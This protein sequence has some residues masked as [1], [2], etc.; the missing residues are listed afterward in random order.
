MIM[1]D[2][3]LIFLKNRVDTLKVSSFL[4]VHN[5]LIRYSP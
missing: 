5:P 4:F 3:M 2:E 1:K